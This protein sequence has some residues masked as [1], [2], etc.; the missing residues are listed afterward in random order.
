MSSTSSS[1]Y[2]FC[3]LLIAGSSVLLTACMYSVRSTSTFGIAHVL[4]FPERLSVA[5]GASCGFPAGVLPEVF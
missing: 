4:K 1:M 2:Y 5:P 3:N